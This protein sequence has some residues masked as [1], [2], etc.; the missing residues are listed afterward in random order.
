[1]NRQTLHE[2]ARAVSAL[3]NAVAPIL[4][5]KDPSI[6]GAILADLTATW[7]AGHRAATKEETDRMRDELLTM[8]IEA[9]E[10][11]IALNARG[12]A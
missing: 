7:I 8:H 11:L 9:I 10:A 4:A 12:G 2:Q 1:M 3:V 6:V 5:S